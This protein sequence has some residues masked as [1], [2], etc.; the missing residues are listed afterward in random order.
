MDSLTTI[1]DDCGHLHVCLHSDTLPP[2]PGTTLPFQN[3]ADVWPDEPEIY[4]R[5]SWASNGMP[6][7]GFLP[8]CPSDIYKCNLFRCLNFTPLSLPIFSPCPGL[9]ALH[10]TLAEDWKNLEGLLECLRKILEGRI[11]RQRSVDHHSFP[12]PWQYG[13]RHAKSSKSAVILAAKHSRDAFLLMAAEISFLLALASVDV[14]GYKFDTWSALLAEEV[15]HRWVDLVRNSWL[16]EKDTGCWGGSE[17]RR[18]GLFIDPRT[19]NFVQFV[20][21][22]VAFNVPVWFDWG[23]STCIFSPEDPDLLRS[24]PIQLPPTRICPRVAAPLYSASTF[25]IITGKW[26]RRITG[27]VFKLEWNNHGDDVQLPWK[28]SII[29][30]SEE[31]SKNQVS[32]EPRA[33]ETISDVCTCQR[34]GETWQEFFT[35]R[36]LEAEQ[37]I[38]CESARDMQK[39]KAREHDAQRKDCPTYGVNVFFWGAVD[40]KD[41]LVRQHI[42][43]RNVPDIWEDYTP[44][45][46]RYSSLWK[47]WDLNH[48]FDGTIL[49]VTECAQTDDREDVFGLTMDLEPACDDGLI[50]TDGSG[51]SGNGILKNLQEWEEAYT[52]KYSFIVKQLES[53]RRK[54]PTLERVLRYRFGLT[55]LPSSSPTS[56]LTLIEKKKE[57]LCQKWLGSC[58]A[59]PDNHKQFHAMDR[60]LICLTEGFE[61][62]ASIVTVGTNKVKRYSGQFPVHWWDLQPRSPHY[63]ASFPSSLKVTPVQSQ[64]QEFTGYQLEMISSS[65]KVPYILLVHRASDV[66]HCLR[67]SNILS[68]DNVVEELCSLGIAFTMA[69]GTKSPTLSSNS[70]Q[71]PLHNPEPI[72]YRP[73]GFKTDLSDYSY[74]LW[75][76][77]ALFAHPAILRAALMQGGIIW[78]IALDHIQDSNFVLSGPDNS[79]SQD[80][81]SYELRDKRTGKVYSQIWAEKLRSDQL[82]VISGVLL[83]TNL[84]RLRSS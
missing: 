10:Q 68:L 81:K 31:E 25:D 9:W 32:S 23:P 2:I 59:P 26:R 72:L 74:Y 56:P 52:Q 13:Y 46:R 65:D 35:R 38:Q 1:Q 60:D 43:L 54:G 15:G 45:Q 71:Q 69:L 29:S 21:A 7:Q 20:R 36:E 30:S 47:E 48:E 79:V 44:S 73:I 42:P 53:K 39:R 16:V 37:L 24:F 22:Y 27:E 58:S 66:L 18:V 70:S 14:D 64:D 11:V 77:A 78:R 19:C 51:S 63:L 33:P 80:G 76:R 67:L 17:S 84:N 28:T 75:R 61:W 83:A 5:R 40:G 8:T 41:Y 34:L 50:S 55:I 3:P 57:G 49:H 4:I 6:Y 62:V 82:D 12:L